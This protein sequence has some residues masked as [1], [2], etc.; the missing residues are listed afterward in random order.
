MDVTSEG[1]LIADYLDAGFGG[2]LG[3]G[4]KRAYLLIDL[5]NAYL[6][7]TSPL[8]AGEHGAEAVAANA[9]LLQAAREAGVPVIHTRISLGADGQACG[10]FIKKVPSL[11]VFEAGNV[12]AEAPEALTP[13]PEEKIL[14]KHFAS[15]FFGTELA[16][17]LRSLDVDTVVI[18][19]ASTSGCV[20]A[21]ALDA[22][23]S[24]FIP[25]VVDAAC[26]DRDVRPHENTLFDLGAK[27]AEI[28]TL[29]EA[30]S[31]F[32]ESPKEGEPSCD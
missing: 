25:L 21:S 9:Q 5:T 18:G 32:N 8:Y 4:K 31:L 19:G 28:V 26:L 16:D 12:L 15:A 10:L 24:G 3:R 17:H 23:Q 20:R 13:Q 14:M 6:H 1:D 11:R 30:V 27:Y 29:V 7:D 2:D 22:M